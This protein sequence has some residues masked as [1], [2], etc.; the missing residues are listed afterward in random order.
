MAI[1]IINTPDIH[2]TASQLAE[3]RHDYDKEFPMYRGL[4]PDFEEWVAQQE[5]QKGK[6]NP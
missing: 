3:Y 6:V 4:R 2:L 5:K 1:R